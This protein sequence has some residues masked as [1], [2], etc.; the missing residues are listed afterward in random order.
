MQPLRRP[1]VSPLLRFCTVP[2]RPVPSFP[3][4]LAAVCR[5]FVNRQP[6]PPLRQQIREAKLAERL[7]EEMAEDNAAGVGQ[8]PAKAT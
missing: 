6:S 7:A 2:A 3:E 8:A 1:S 5:W 4:S